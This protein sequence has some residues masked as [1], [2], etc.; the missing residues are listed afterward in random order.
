LKNPLAIKQTIKM[1]CSNKRGLE[2][3]KSEHRRVRML[4]VFFG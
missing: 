3:R 4:K 1:S 2:H